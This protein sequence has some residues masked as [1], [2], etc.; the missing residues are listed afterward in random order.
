M[1]PQDK[2]KDIKLYRKHLDIEDTDWL[3][4]RV[5]HLTEALNYIK[6]ECDVGMFGKCKP[7]C[8]ACIAK[9]ALEKKS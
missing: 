1:N 4:N 7:M 3:I 5:E 6:G 9:E 8:A 2:L